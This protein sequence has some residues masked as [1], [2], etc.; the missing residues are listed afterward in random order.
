MRYSNVHGTGRGD[1]SNCGEG[2]G[3]GFGPSND[4]GGDGSCDP[5]PH[6]VGINGNL[7]TGDGNG[8]G[9]DG[10]NEGNGGILS[11]I[12]SNRSHQLLG[13][14]FE[15]HSDIQSSVVLLA[16]SSILKRPH[17]RV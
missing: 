2:D 9:E 6:G 13:L 7:E 3:T 8:Y 5:L 17:H 1:G 12:G 14:W 4:V 11:V 15:N 10:G 16:L